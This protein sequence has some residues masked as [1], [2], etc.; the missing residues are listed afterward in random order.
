M[1]LVCVGSPLV[2]AQTGGRQA[3]AVEVLSGKL[4]DGSNY[5]AVKPAAWNGTLVLDLDFVNDPTAPPTAIEQWMVANGYAIGVIS[6][7]PIAYR[8]PAAVDDLLTVRTM[9]IERWGMPMRTLSLGNSRGA[10]VS[11]VA[12]ERRPDIFVGAM[13]SAGGGAGEV[14]L[15]NAK[16]DAL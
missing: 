6:R 3:G 9:F 5:R 15:H 14:A 1:V 2:F 8:F 16:L 7:E 12:L 4:P 10:F 11:R 13:L